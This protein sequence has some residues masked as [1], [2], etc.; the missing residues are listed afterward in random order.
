MSSLQFFVARLFNVFEF[1]VGLIF[2][3]SGLFFLWLFYFD[4]MSNFLL[5]FV[6]AAGFGFG[7]KAISESIKGM[8]AIRQ[9]IEKK[10]VKCTH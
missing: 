3:I 8:V 4:G 10:E 5:L 7:F 1:S 6:V 9:A 2:V